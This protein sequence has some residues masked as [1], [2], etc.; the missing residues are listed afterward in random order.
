MFVPHPSL[1]HL[2]KELS[3]IE[4]VC[5]SSQSGTLR[6]KIVCTKRAYKIESVTSI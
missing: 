3:D 1:K 2:L 6:K 5:P 4:D